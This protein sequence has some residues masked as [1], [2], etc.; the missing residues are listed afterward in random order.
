MI[1]GVLAK[2]KKLDGSDEI[3]QSMNFAQIQLDESMQ[4]DDEVAQLHKLPEVS[5]DLV[6]N[7]GNDKKGTTLSIQFCNSSQFRSCA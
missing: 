3:G 5:N 6:L 4:V 2:K 1:M 7:D